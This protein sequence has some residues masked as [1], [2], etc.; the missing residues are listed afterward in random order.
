MRKGHQHIHPGIAR[1]GNLSVGKGHPVWLQ[2]MTKTDTRDTN[3]TVK[4]CIE[5][6][7]QGAALMRIS[8]PD[9]TALQHFTLIQ[10]KIR[11]AGFQN[12][13]AAD[14]HY[15]ADL[16]I[17]AARVAQKI[18]INPGNFVSASKRENI[19]SSE[20]PADN[21]KELTYNELR[22]LTDVCNNNGTAIRIGVNA[23][24]LPPHIIRKFGHTS[25]AL[26]EATAEYLEILENLRFFN[27]VISIKSS[28]IRETVDACRA[29]QER[30]QMQGRFYPLHI[31]VTEAG[32]GISGRMKSAAGILE[33]LHSGIGDTLRVSLSES[34]VNEILFGKELLRFAGMSTDHPDTLYNHSNHHL[35]IHSDAETPDPLIADVVWQFISHKNQTIN[36][37]TI[38]APGFSDQG[39]IKNVSDQLLQVSGVRIVETEFVGCPGCARTEMDMEGLCGEVK[40]RFS[41]FPGLKI[42]VMGCMVNGPGEMGDADYGLIASGKDSLILYKGQNPIGKY[43]DIKSALHHLQKEI[44][45]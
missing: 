14:I 16:A 18:R 23:G 12:P 6:F 8:I 27:T 5:S 25:S 42:A 26:V 2:S 35:S 43:A 3:A 7:E 24:S 37:L 34:P 39:I 36:D 13:L 44:N 40:K 33:L 31:G 19:A 10:K 41:G 4:Q 22:K 21:Y 29:I 38:R 45:H 17:E 28:R 9:R 32:N 11:Q 1:V 15:R 20:H 30:M